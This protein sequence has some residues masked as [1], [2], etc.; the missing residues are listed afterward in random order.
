M[1]VGANGKQI[2]RSARNDKISWDIVEGFSILPAPYLIYPVRFGYT[3]G[4]PRDST[5]SPYPDFSRWLLRSLTA[6]CQPGTTVS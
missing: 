3:T 1:F 2:P 5:S 6:R 4:G